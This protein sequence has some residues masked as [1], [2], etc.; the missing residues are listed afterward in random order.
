LQ[1]VVARLALTA[2]S[3]KG[4]EFGEKRERLKEGGREG[5]GEKR[6]SSDGKD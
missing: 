2:R 6:E 1:S 3:Q 5:K 4:R